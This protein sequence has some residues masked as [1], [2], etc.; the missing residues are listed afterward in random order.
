MANGFF[1]LLLASQ[2]YLTRSIAAYNVLLATMGGTKSHTVPFIAL[3]TILKER[4]HNVTL[5]SAFT[6]PAANNALRELVPPVLE[7][8][9]P[10]KFLQFSS[11]VLFFVIKWNA[12]GQANNRGS[13]QSEGSSR[14]AERDLFNF[15]KYL[16]EGV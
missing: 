2:L 14:F 4:G 16:I 11:I 15:Q 12:F 9:I 5:F 3:G 10:L 6:G 8:G 1:Y 7:V 13:P